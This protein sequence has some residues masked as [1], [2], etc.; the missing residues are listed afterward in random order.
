MDKL[1]EFRTLLVR[2]VKN[3]TKRTL[4]VSGVLAILLISASLLI[5]LVAC[6][7]DGNANV[8]DE[9]PIV[10]TT[11][12]TTTTTT[13]ATTTTS[14]TTEVATTELPETTI[15]TE[16]TSTEVATT[17]PPPPTV[18][19][20]PALQPTQA[21]QPQPTNPPPTN[22]PQRTDPPPQPTGGF[23]EA[24]MHELKIYAESIGF[25]DVEIT[26][27]V[28]ILLVVRMSG[29]PARSRLNIELDPGDPSGVYTSAV[30]FD[31]PRGVATMAEARALID[32]FRRQFP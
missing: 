1:K 10:T 11:V 18:T 3:P 30:G 13:P 15:E 4:V 16:E 19:N 14:A 8:E 23:T 21:P 5:F 6:S 28:G 25:T 24:R 12:E 2:K 32:S 9:N 31:T 29:D 17:A 27:S 26:H 7:E 20:P 22:P